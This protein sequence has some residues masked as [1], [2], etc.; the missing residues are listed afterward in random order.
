MYCVEDVMFDQADKFVQFLQFVILQRHKG[1]ERRVSRAAIKVKFRQGLAQCA[2]PREFDGNIFH[3]TILVAVLKHEI[4]E[5]VDNFIGK[6]FDCSIAKFFGRQV[7]EPPE[8]YADFFCAL[9]RAC[10]H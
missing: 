9:L 10:S 4:A 7:L 2:A 3:D 5:Q 6:G 1:S 8:L